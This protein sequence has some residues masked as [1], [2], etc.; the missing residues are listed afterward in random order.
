MTRVTYLEHSA[1]AVTL[2]DAILVFDYVRDPS[3]A[4]KRI[5][6]K[7]PE[8]PVI[9]FATHN[10]PDHYSKS[11]YEIAQNHNRTYVLSNDIPAMNV[12]TTLSV[13]GISAGDV[14]DNLPGGVSVKAYKSTDKGVSL[15]VT[16]STGQKIFHAGDLNDW[17]WSE[18]S[19]E[20]EIRKA[21]EEFK[22]IVNHIA[23]EVP[24]VDIAMFPVDVRQGADYARG[25]RYFLQAIKVHDFFPMHF[26]GDYHKACDFADYAPEGVSC[27]CLHEPGESIELSK[28]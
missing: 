6:D 20:R 21:D 19:T 28:V 24:A 17:T 13:A 10:H 16:T 27:H 3:H 12:P 9:F 7:N 18:E 14:I 15:L 5:L 22:V 4:L 1:F 23:S 11:V 2:S 25:A 8:L 26:N